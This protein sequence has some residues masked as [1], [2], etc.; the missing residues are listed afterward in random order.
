MFYW[1]FNYS[2]GVPRHRVYWVTK[3]T[4]K[5]ETVLQDIT[6]VHLPLVITRNLL[7]HKFVC[8]SEAIDGYVENT[9]VI[10]DINS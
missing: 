3:L 8:V 1:K 9:T 7:L 5:T 2:A 4:Q 6:R 10:V